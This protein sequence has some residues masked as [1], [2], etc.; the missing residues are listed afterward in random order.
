MLSE[1]RPIHFRTELIFPPLNLSTEERAQK[2]RARIK[3]VFDKVRTEKG[4]DFNKMD[5]DAPS[6]PHLWSRRPSGHVTSYS[7][8]GD[9][10]KAQDEWTERTLSEFAQDVKNVMDVCFR[11]FRIPVVVIQSCV[12]RATAK[13]HPFT[14]SRNFLFSHGLGLTGRKME[15]FGRPVH[16]AG[17]NMLFPPAQDARDEQRV[18]IE[19]YARDPSQLF[20]E[21]RSTFQASPIPPTNQ[22]LLETNLDKCYEFLERHVCAFV[23]SLFEEKRDIEG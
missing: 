19:S 17:I 13:P 22:S 9:R 10:I 5:V 16:V 3:E 6:G 8:L 1:L 18:R 15:V 12:I 7:F 2:H 4:I 23:N 20:L 21:V 11:V 14:D